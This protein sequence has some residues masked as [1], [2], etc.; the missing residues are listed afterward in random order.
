MRQKEDNN[1]KKTNTIND[2]EEQKYP[3]TSKYYF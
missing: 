1:I 2:I 3:K